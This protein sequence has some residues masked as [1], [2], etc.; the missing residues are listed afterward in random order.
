MSGLL[1]GRVAL[2]TGAGSG[3][4]R[5]VTHA[6]HGAGASVVLTGRRRDRLEASAHGLVRARVAPA[7]VREPDAVDA[8]ARAHPDVDLLVL[9]AG[10]AVAG[11]VD[12]LDVEAFD[13]VMATNVRGVF[14]LC[15]AFLPGLRAHPRSDVVHLG[16]VA[17][18]RSFPNMGAYGP[19]K[20]AAAALLSVV[21][22]ENRAHGVRVIDAVVGATD[23]DIWDDV[24]PDA[25]RAAMM[26]AE[27]VARALVGALAAGE[28]AGVE[29]LVIRPVGGDL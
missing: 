18:R 17:A 24:W 20:A 12:A 2:V 10:R 8:L 3:I 27:S 6:L 1:D 23:T 21:R 25:P 13:D 22:E 16:S 15:R 9:A 29:E 4:G 5:A 7:D 19:S 28:D 11:P 14:L 26:S